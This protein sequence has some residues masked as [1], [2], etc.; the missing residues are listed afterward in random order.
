MFSSVFAPAEELVKPDGSR[1]GIH[2]LLADKKV[3]ALYFS[4]QWCRPCKA[5]L[6]KLI[7]FYNAHKA[8]GL[9]IVFI[10]QD[11]DKDAFDEYQKDMP[12][13]ALPFEHR[14]VNSK[15]L[16][17]FVVLGFPV[18]LLFNSA[19]RIVSRRGKDFVNDMP[20]QFPWGI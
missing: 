6:P 9:E 16:E 20:D 11:F 18:L 12:W 4:A 1:E 3:V 8:E 7:H 19:G 10:S 15:L 5:F 13:P 2:T 17:S 14:A